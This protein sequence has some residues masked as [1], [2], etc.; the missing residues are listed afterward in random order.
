M[1]ENINSFMSGYALLIIL[2]WLAFNAAFAWWL[3]RRSRRR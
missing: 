1:K 3:H 2:A